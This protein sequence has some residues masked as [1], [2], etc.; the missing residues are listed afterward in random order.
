MNTASSGR[1]PLEAG[2]VATALGGGRWRAEV[3]AESPS[4]NAVVAARLRAGEPEGLVVVADHQTAGRGRLDRSWVTPAGAAL[5]FSV[6]LTPDEAP[7]ARWPWL[8]LLTGVAVAEGVRRTVGVDV[9]LK[10]P[11]DVLAEERKVCGILVERVDG[12]RRAGAVVGVGLNVSQTA[13][14]LPVPTATSLERAAGT[15]VDRVAL[16]AGI[17]EALAARYDAWRAAGAEPRELHAA[18]TEL[19]DTLGRTVRVRLPSGDD[20]NGEAV[21]IDADGRLVVRTSQG[22]TVLGAGDVIH[23]R[24]Q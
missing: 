2:A 17:L 3:L 4:T 18:Y 5:T 19:C 20:L 7:V 16:L 9:A 8:P 6:L 1:P 24:P 14:E 22:E 23:V 21:R 15:T 11:N 10:W 12:P 13:G